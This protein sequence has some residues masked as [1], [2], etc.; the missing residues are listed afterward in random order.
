V[1]PTHIYQ[2]N[3]LYTVTLTIIGG[4]GHDTRVKEDLIAVGPRA[5]LAAA[6]Q[7]S[8]TDEPIWWVSLAISPW[9][10][11]AW[12]VADRLRDPGVTLPEVVRNG[13]ALAALVEAR[14]PET[15]VGALDLALERF[16]SDALI[17]RR[18]AEPAIADLLDTSRTRLDG[19]RQ[20]LLLEAVLRRAEPSGEGLDQAVADV[21]ERLQEF[22]AAVEALDR[23][24]G[25]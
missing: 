17:A 3:G 22:V 16:L 6:R 18:R 13:R 12:L 20:A 19:L 9:V 2:D 4:N 5:Q 10:A 25:T 24:T 1:H 7:T 21:Q 11:G 8:I 14:G 15:S 23:E